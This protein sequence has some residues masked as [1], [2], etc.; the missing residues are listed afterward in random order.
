M[1]KAILL[2]MTETVH[3]LDKE[4]MYKEFQERIAGHFRVSFDEFK[5]AYFK[6]YS[7]YQVGLIENDVDFFKFIE[8]LTGA[9][10]TDDERSH[11]IKEHA[12]CRVHFIEI[13]P[14]LI[15]TLDYLKSK[16]KLGLVSNCVWNWALA[17]FKRMN[18]NPE[19]YF[20]VMVD[21]QHFHMLKPNPRIYL[22][23]LNK[24]KIAPGDAAFVGDSVFDINGAYFTGFSNLVLFKKPNAISHYA[25]YLSEGKLRPK[26][27]THEID[28]L[29]E[30]KSIF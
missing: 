26:Q 29:T 1:V 11:V 8:K 14:G 28:N 23:A 4:R 21:S 13:M 12:D 10:L 30:L 9:T 3:T 5:G 22:E 25:E 20:E 18:F 19:Q 2:D 27:V 7:Y 17:D 16:Y 15:E 24:L 6:A